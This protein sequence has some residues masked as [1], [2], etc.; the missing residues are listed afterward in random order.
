MFSLSILLFQSKTAAKGDEAENSQN[1]VDIITSG[2]PIS[3]AIFSILLI[4]SILALYIF[5]ER[6]LTIKRATRIDD[7]FMNN[8]RAA[9]VSLHLQVSQ[10]LRR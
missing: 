4:L 2:G 1:L 7:N 6:W 5:I 8:I 3:I 9:V 10:V